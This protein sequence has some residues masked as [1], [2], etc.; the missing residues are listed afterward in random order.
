MSKKKTGL[1]FGTFNPIHIG[2]CVIAQHMLEFTDLDEVW[3]VVTPHNPHKKKNTLL[4]DYQRLHMVQL[5]VDDQYKMQVSNMEFDLPQPSYTATTLAH[6]VEKYPNH[7][8]SLIMGADNLETFHKWRNYEWILEH[9]HIYV[10]PRIESDGGDLKLHPHVTITEAP[11]MQIASTDIRNAIK[12]GKNVSFML[13][14][15]VWKYVDEEL[16]YR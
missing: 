16:F 6:A 2:H 14:E 15:K 3:F 12:D 8:F 10:Y 11:I 4:D 9:H 7:E 1:Y 13:P 5:A